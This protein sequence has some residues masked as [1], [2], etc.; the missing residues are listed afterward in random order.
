M[1]L[2]IITGNL[3]TLAKQ[4]WQAFQQ[5]D[6]EDFIKKFSHLSHLS[7]TQA[8]LKIVEKTELKQHETMRDPKRKA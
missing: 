8:K 2:K 7:R 5:D 4:T 6:M 3:E 1:A